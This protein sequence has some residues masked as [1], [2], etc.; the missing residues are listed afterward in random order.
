MTSLSDAAWRAHQKT[1]VEETRAQGDEWASHRAELTNNAYRVRVAGLKPEV[2]L[3]LILWSCLHGGWVIEGMAIFERLM[4]MKDE[5]RWTPLSW[6]S[7]VSDEPKDS[8]D[9]EKVEYLFNNWAPSSI[10]PPDRPSPISVQRTISS[11][12]VN[13]YIDASISTL[14]VSREMHGRSASQVVEF[15]GRT[16]EFLHRSGLSLGAGSWDAIILRLFDLKDDMLCDVKLFDKIMRLSPTIGQEIAAQNTRGLPEYVFDGSAG[17]LGLFHRALKSRIRAADV[18]GALRLF[19]SL[20]ERADENKRQSIVDFLERQEVFANAD[21]E[22]D[23]NLFT[24]NYSRIEYPGFDVQIPA[25]TLG[26]FLDLIV[27]AKAYD[28]GKW[29]LYS[30]EIDGP[31]I[32]ERLYGDPALTPALIRFATETNDKVLLA[33]LVKAR[34]DAAKEDEP[35][36]PRN[37]LQ[38]FL[39]SQISLRRWDAA[40]RI[41]R[42]MKNT[43]GFSWNT[44]TLSRMILAMLL[45]V[46]QNS[47]DG[48]ASQH[49]RNLIRRIINDMVH[50]KYERRGERPNWAQEQIDNLLIVLATVNDKW[51]H[52]CFAPRPIDG[53]RVFTLPSKAFNFTLEG[54]VDAYGSLAGRQLV[55]R[56]WSEAIREAQA[57]EKLGDKQATQPPYSSFGSQLPH[58]LRRQRT[59][60]QITEE[61]PRQVIM[62]GGLRPDLL[63][64]RIVLREAM[65]ELASN[66]NPDQGGQEVQH[67]RDADIVSQ[68]PYPNETAIASMDSNTD[69]VVWAV[70]RLQHLGM[71]PDDIYQE[72]QD[73]LTADKLESILKANPGLLS[74]DNDDV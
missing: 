20:Q 63:T 60:V 58:F 28:F 59:V 38:S 36:L 7:L 25:I 27:D 17:I 50:G 22:L 66:G 61:P 31:V 62:Y 57:T 3:E 71:I 42:H 1:L 53:Y 51:A 16:Q 73:G 55:D 5:D 6:R 29:L 74:Q 30:D 9:W 23:G 2:W 14:R 41:L 44:A 52:Y 68:D 12:L 32:P 65:A 19:T 39:D 49:E 45:R 35:T 67:I 56:F 70:Q 47:E 69:T 64:I 24:E 33:S 4:K 37:V 54:V 8:R 34:A 40:I 10:D 18:E 15:L 13:A 26:P 72:L 48:S 46:R 43:F 21:G 11:E